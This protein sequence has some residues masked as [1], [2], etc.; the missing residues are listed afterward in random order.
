MIKGQ[1]KDEV[2]ETRVQWAGDRADIN[3]PLRGKAPF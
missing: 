3:L 2:G 1:S